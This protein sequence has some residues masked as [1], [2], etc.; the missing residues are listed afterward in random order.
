MKRS[1]RSARIPAAV[2]SETH[3]QL[4]M[5]AL[6]ASAAGAGL[7]ALPQSA[8]AKIVY[9]PAHRVIRAN[10]GF[11]LDLNHDG[12]TDFLLQ[13]IG[14]CNS[15]SCY[16]FQR[17]L[18]A[19]G[20]LGNVVEGRMSNGDTLNYKFYY[21]S[22]LRLGAR[23]GPHQHFIGGGSNGAT[24]LAVFQDQD[25]QMPYTYGKWIDVKNR[26]L[27]LKFKIRGKI[28]YGWARLSVHNHGGQITATLTGY[29]YE[30]VPNKAIIA[31]KTKGIDETSIEESNVASTVPK[32]KP[33]T[34]GL[35]ALG[36]YGTSIWRR[37]E[38]A[39]GHY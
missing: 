1:L 34:L 26:Y 11:Q 2:S 22:A 38:W 15:D 10:S 17:Y 36:S 14:Y 39:S 16:G 37:E 5:Y 31:G 4:K 12:T 8:E 28:H 35:L 13:Q 33:T 25:L 3:H 32:R 30:T 27:G 6:A 23:I 18:L 20:S 7:L 19:K 21:A 24:M 29:A 9:T